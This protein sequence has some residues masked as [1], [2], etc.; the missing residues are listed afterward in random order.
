MP[1]TRAIRFSA[2]AWPTLIQQVDSQSSELNE[3]SQGHG[4]SLHV[5]ET[6]CCDRKAVMALSVGVVAE[7]TGSRPPSSTGKSNDPGVSGATCLPEQNDQR[8]GLGH[9]AGLEHHLEFAAVVAFDD[10]KIGLALI[11]H[12][13]GRIAVESDQEFLRVTVP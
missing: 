3:I 9:R 8:F 7:E 1:I 10:Q 4:L 12:R 5:G 6:E 13:P 11:E 2:S